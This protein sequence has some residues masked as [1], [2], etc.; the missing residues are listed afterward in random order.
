MEPQ[1][2][3]EQ[4][5]LKASIERNTEAFGT[6][7]RKYQSYICTLTYSAIGR[8]EESEDIAQNVFVAV[9]QNLSQLRDVGK[10]KSWMCQITK[11]EIVKYYQRRQRDILSKS[12]TSAAASTA[13]TSQAGPVEQAISREREDFVHQ[14]LGRSLSNTVSR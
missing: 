3:N 8:I 14:A 12:I 13:K 2:F 11:N 1:A 5:L 7:V 10:F 6:L 9:W 4:A